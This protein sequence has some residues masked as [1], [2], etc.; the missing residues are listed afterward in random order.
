VSPP[1]GRSGRLA[2]LAESPPVGRRR[3]WAIHAPSLGA[4]V[5]VTLWSPAGV[6]DDE[7]APLLVVHDGPAY[8]R[9]S[10]LTHYLAVGIAGGRMPP[11]RAALLG[12]ADRDDWYS[13]NDA[14]SRALAGTVL[15]ELAG[16]V[17]IRRKIGMGTS[18][19]ALAMLH[20]HQSGSGLFDA[21]FLQSGSFFQP[22]FDAQEAGFAHYGR[23][24]AFVAA[25]ISG[26]VDHPV[27]TVMT[28]GGS[29]ENIDNNRAMATALRSQGY[30]VMLHEG[31]GGHDFSAWRDAL[32]PPLRRLLV[33]GRRRRIPARPPDR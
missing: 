14:Y 30:P 5:E 8:D 20:A 33:G 11:V 2:W 21:L 16:R 13:A 18:L 24:V 12:A 26:E 7:P 15:P 25:V 6:V 1:A 27:P 22:V 29:E 10:R 3:E 28:C 9:E 32:D 31:P 4:A 19:G 23:I 17:P